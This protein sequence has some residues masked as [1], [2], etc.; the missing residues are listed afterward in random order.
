MQGL[1]GLGFRVDAGWVHGRFKGGFK[2]AGLL[3]V[4]RL[5]RLL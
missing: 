3:L 2:V 1:V 5:C 4:L